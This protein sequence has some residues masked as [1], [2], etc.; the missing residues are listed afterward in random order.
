MKNGKIS[1][2]TKEMTGN[3]QNNLELHFRRLQVYV[4]VLGGWGCQL[5]VRPE[6]VSSLGVA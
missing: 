2:L 6:A 5:S 1:I 4:G 3:S